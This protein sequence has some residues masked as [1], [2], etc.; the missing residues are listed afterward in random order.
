MPEQN[1]SR[2]VSVNCPAGSYYKQMKCVP[3]A[4]GQY[5][6]KEGQTKCKP[7]PAAGTTAVSGAVSR[8][9]CHGKT[10]DGY[11]CSNYKYCD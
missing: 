8:N 9:E 3:C 2:V 11:L 10:Y 4:M 5:Q 1:R 6:D 7:C